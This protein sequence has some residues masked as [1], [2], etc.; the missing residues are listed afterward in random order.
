MGGLHWV[1]RLAGT[2]DPTFW[3]TVRAPRVMVLSA[4]LYQ[5]H[6]QRIQSWNEL[7]DGSNLEKPIQA[8]L[9]GCVVH[10]LRRKVICK[11]NTTVMV[12]VALRGGR[13]LTLLWD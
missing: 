4:F 13:G 10:I 12:H 6:T 3:R 7:S 5:Q 8:R 1:F 9:F 2:I 11:T